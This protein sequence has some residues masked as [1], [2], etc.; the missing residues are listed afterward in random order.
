[1]KD[2]V[3]SAQ[4][5]VLAQLAW[6]LWK[7]PSTHRRAASSASLIGH[8]SSGDACRFL[9]S[10]RH[11]VDQRPTALQVVWATPEAIDPDRVAQLENTLAV[12]ALD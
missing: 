11:E 12:D 9:P 10:G 4:S 2:R 1:M 8:W 7:V 5:H 6:P 3:V